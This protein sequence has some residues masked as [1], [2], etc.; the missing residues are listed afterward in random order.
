[1]NR[2]PVSSTNLRS[3]GY[4]PSTSTLEVEFRHGGIYQYFDVPA[5]RYDGLLSAYS[6]GG[7]FDAFIKNGGYAYHRVELCHHSP[8]G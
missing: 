1:M 2:T 6:K 7:Y 3:V 4:D 5:A 8:A